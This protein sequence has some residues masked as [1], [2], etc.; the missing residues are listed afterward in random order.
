MPPGGCSAG[1]DMAKLAALPKSRM[2][3]AFLGP[4]AQAFAENAGP[5]LLQQLLEGCVRAFW[6][7][8]ERPWRGARAASLASARIAALPGVRRAVTRHSIGINRYTTSP[9]RSRGATRGL[10]RGRAL[11]QHSPNPAEGLV[12]A[13]RWVGFGGAGGEIIF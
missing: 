2:E 13:G 4:G 7:A 10:P 9:E 11:L 1:V 6:P 12:A 8:R 5:A 3:P